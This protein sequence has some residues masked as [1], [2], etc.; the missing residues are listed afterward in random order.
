MKK[1][2]RK[3]RHV[4]FDYEQYSIWE[5]GGLRPSLRKGKDPIKEVS[6]RAVHNYFFVKGLDTLREGGIMAFITSR[7]VL[8]SP[9]NEPIRRYLMENS[10]LIS[11]LRLPDKMFSENAERMSEVI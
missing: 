1:S 10:R 7:G 6:T 9:K 5:Y 8:D 3:K 2:C 11:A 4:R